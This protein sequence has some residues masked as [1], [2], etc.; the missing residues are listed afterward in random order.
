VSA[1][2]HRTVAELLADSDELARETLLDATLEHAPAMVRSWNQLVGS[3]AELWTGL[4]LGIRQP[5]QIADN[6]SRAWSH[7]DH[8]DELH[9][10]SLAGSSTSPANGPLMPVK[11]DCAAQCEASDGI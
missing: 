2:D 10:A 11:P 4:A 3:A 5:A 1:A 7:G 6:L 8:A 9:R